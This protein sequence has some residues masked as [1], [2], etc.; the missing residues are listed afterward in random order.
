M[1]RAQ[2]DALSGDGL[3]GCL[4]MPLDLVADG[5]ADEVGAIGVEA[6]LHQ[7]VDM[8]E[9]DVAEIDRDLLGVATLAS[10]LNYVVVS[11]F[12]HPN[13]IQLDGKWGCNPGHQGPRAVK[14][15]RPVACPRG[16]VEPCEIDHPLCRRAVVNSSLTKPEQFERSSA[17]ARQA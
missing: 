9:I 4:R 12:D 13:A 8:A 14:S 16:D 17:N 7:K 6:L 5:G 1:A 15:E 2:F 10:E 11:H 3:L